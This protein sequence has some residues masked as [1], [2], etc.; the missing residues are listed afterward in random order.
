MNN[1]I[2]VYLK[3][4]SQFDFQ[5]VSLQCKPNRSDLFMVIVIIR[6]VKQ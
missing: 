2:F 6:N 4:Y 3:V 5:R 1:Y